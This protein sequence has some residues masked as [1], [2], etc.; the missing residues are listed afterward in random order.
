MCIR[1]RINAGNSGG[2]LVDIDGRVIGVNQLTA[3]PSLAQGIGFAIPSNSVR[4]VS[5]QLA[6]S[7][8]ITQGTHE[9]YIGVGLA[10]LTEGARSQLGYKGPQGVVVAQVMCRGGIETVA[11]AAPIKRTE[12][13]TLR[14]YFRTSSW[15]GR[16]VNRPAWLSAPGWSGSL[17]PVSMKSVPFGEKRNGCP[18]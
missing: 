13:G 6:K 2:P 11:S 7:T 14:A 8:G 15:S 3:N 17:T 1:D 4:Q 5:A 9:G 16:S 10:A 12:E 18:W